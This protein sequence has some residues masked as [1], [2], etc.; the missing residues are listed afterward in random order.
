MAWETVSVIADGYAYRTWTESTVEAGAA[1]ASRGFSIIAS[2]PNQMFIDAWPLRP[3]VDVRVTASGEP[4]LRGFI[5]TYAPEFGL[6]YHRAVISGRSAS[7]D[8]VDSSAI[9]D[10]GEWK[11]KKIDEIANDLLKPFKMKIQVGVKDLKPIPVWRLAPGATVFEE[12]EA[13]ARSQGLLIVGTADGG[14]KLTRADQFQMHAGA[15]VEGYNIKRASGSLSERGRHDKVHARGQKNKGS[16]AEAQRL[17]SVSRDATVERHRPLLILAEGDMTQDLIKER[18]DWQVRRSAGWAVQATIEVAGW[19]DENGALW[20]PEKLVYVESKKLKLSQLMAIRH[21][22]FLQNSDQGT[23]ATL[24][25]VDPQALGGKSGKN[26]S[27]DA[28]SSGV[29]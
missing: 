11:K 25:L 13:M 8:V 10:S 3:G 21:V 5:D 18:A 23:M 1:H 16:G 19:R 27:N 29:Q 7:K 14:L 22:R 2:E 15:L 28:W 9:H 12:I 4:L 6:D 20:D 24:A 17:E 26:G